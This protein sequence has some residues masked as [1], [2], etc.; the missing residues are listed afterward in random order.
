MKYLTVL[1]FS[2]ILSS[3]STCTTKNKIATT[4]TAEEIQTPKK[5]TF[6]IH[7]LNGKNVEGDKLYIV[8]NKENNTVSGYSGCN[9]F[10]CKYTQEKDIISFAL[11]MAS[12]MYCPKKEALEQ[13]FFKALVAVNTKVI[14]N[15]ALTLKSADG[16]VLFFGKRQ[17]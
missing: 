2:L 17:N 8:F 16:A 14:E 13:E 6:E 11:P 3:N 4:D 9:T 15:D 1:F 5:E 7:R 12:K 10:S